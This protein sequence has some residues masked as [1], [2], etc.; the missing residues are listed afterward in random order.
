MYFSDI[1]YWIDF[2]R[3]TMKVVD[4]INFVVDENQQ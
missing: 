4:E 1:L 3:E 2:V